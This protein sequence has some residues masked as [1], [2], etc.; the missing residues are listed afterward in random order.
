M[1]EQDL[2]EMLRRMSQ[3]KVNRRGFLAAAG[4][5]G[6]AA[7]L[8]A[9][10]SGGTSSAAASASTGAAASAAPSAATG[11][12]AAASYEL[13]GEL[14]TYNWSEYVSEKN[15]AEFTA[16]TGVAYSEDIFA[17]RRASTCRA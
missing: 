9:C 7:A 3:T 12:S 16:R 4:L 8:A 17:A 10:S 5:G 15:K 6:A 13:E 11:P 2:D 14:L 1:A